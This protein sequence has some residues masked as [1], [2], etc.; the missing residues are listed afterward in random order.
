[1]GI[2]KPGSLEQ[3]KLLQPLWMKCGNNLL[4]C[5]CVPFIMSLVKI[6]PK[7]NLHDHNDVCMCVCVC[8]YVYIYSQCSSMAAKKK[9][10][11]NVL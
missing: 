11:L 5:K 8:M 9:E 4:K 6:C 7:V 2:V 10:G 3:Y 1:M